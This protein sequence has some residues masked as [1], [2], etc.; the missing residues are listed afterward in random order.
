MIVDSLKNDFLQVINDARRGDAPEW[1]AT[2]LIR[3]EDIADHTFDV[4]DSKNNPETI[5]RPFGEGVA[6]F[7]NGRTHK[8][9]NLRFIC[10]DEYLHQFVFVDREG[11]T[12]KS[13][14]NKRMADFIIY[15]TSDNHVWFLIQE[16]STSNLNKKRNTGR[17]QLSTTIDLLCRSERIKKFVTP[18]KN[19]WCVLS[20]RDERVLQTPNGMA[21]A[22]MNS[23]TILPEQLQF[24]YGAIRRLG[25][26][27]YETSK[28]ILK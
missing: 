21:D 26:I 16:L 14:L 4:D 2:P 25:F 1:L 15:D 9:Y 6:S 8:T 7:L 23:Y 12:N 19:K 5:K 24:Q 27:G 22:F 18:F 28:I 20:A 11:H 10:Y 17:I 13:M 3:F